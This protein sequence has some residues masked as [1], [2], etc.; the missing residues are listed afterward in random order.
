MTNAAKRRGSGSSWAELWAIYRLET[1]CVLYQGVSKYRIPGDR[2]LSKGFRILA[3]AQARWYLSNPDPNSDFSRAS[4]CFNL[5]TPAHRSCACPQVLPSD[6]SNYVCLSPR[7]GRGIG[8]GSNTGSPYRH[9][10][11]PISFR[12]RTLL[13]CGLPLQPTPRGVHRSR[14]CVSLCLNTLDTLVWIPSRP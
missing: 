11:S 3:G 7:Q 14:P 13:P 12:C 9:T 1:S 4:K 5:T 6:D 8:V 2:K 10:S